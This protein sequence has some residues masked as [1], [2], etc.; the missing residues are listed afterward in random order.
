MK[1]GANQKSLQHR[2]MV[3]LGMMLLPLVILGGGALVSLERAISAFEETDNTILEELFPVKDLEVLINEASMVI[4]TCFVDQMPN[5]CDRMAVSNQKVESKYRELLTNPSNLPEKKALIQNSYQS[6]Q[7][8]QRQIQAITSAS[9]PA[10]I[11]QQQQVSLDTAVF[12]TVEV[13]DRIQ[14]LM[15]HYQTADNLTQARSIKQSVRF[16]ISTMFG[17]GLGVAGVAGW[18]LARSILKPISILQAGVNS[19]GDGQLSHRIQLESQDELGQLAICFNQM[20]DTLEQNQAEL[21]NLATR[22]GL[23]GVFNRREFTKR[24]Q[25]ELTRSQRYGY[26]CSLM[27][28]DIDF[29]KKLNDTYGHQAGDEA[30]K[31]VAALL[32]QAVRPSD[33]VARYGGEEF[34]VIMPETTASDAGIV[35]ERLRQQLVAQP[36]H[37]SEQQTLQV[38]ASIGVATF[39]HDAQADDALLAAADQALYQAKHGGRNQVVCFRSPPCPTENPVRSH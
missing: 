6:W 36:I 17:L 8:Y 33:Q 20:A 24:L 11:T 4:N 25:A 14:I 19:L 34:A 5:A 12:Q 16:I 22:D 35:A 23:T 2:L 10:A 13:L 31:Q 28:F 39:P 15:I 27:M 30:L 18:A 26:P 21:I 38:T 7:H 32:I 29:F 9:L 37:V 3:G 1:R